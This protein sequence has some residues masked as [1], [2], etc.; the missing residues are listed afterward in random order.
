MTSEKVFFLSLFSLSKAKKKT[1]S[2]P[3]MQLVLSEKIV[4]VYI[5]NASKQHHQNQF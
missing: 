2:T 5:S 1:V 3:E 4:L